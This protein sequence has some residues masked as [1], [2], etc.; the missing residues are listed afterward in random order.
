MQIYIQTVYQYLQISDILIR[1]DAIIGATNVN[2][3]N[4]IHNINLGVLFC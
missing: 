3:A 2:P 1:K 4:L